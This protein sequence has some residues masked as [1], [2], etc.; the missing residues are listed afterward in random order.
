[1]FAT[2]PDFRLL[3]IAPQIEA[4]H[5]PHQLVAA[6]GGS[7]Q[8]ERW[9]LVDDF[10][11]AMLAFM[12]YVP[13][14]MLWGFALVDM[15]VRKDLHAWSKCLWALLVLFVPLLGVIIYFIARPKDYDNWDM[16]PAGYGGSAYMPTSYSHVKTEAETTNE[17]LETIS[18]MHDNGKLTDTE[19]ESLK[20][21]LRAA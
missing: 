19:Y 10:W 15:F 8:K 21:R 4:N 20:G 5:R 2:T 1:M 17:Q 13:L 6:A 9:F 18:M 7:R 16:A 14:I 12:I 11:W 3:A